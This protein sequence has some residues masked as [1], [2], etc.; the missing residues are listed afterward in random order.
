[1]KYN[2]IISKGSEI[3][4]VEISDDEILSLFPDD[5][6]SLVN[7]LLRRAQ[8]AEAEIEKLQKLVSAVRTTDHEIFCEDVNEQNWF[9]ARDVVMTNENRICHH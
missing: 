1:M 6:C 7:P 9:D 2:E 3:R 5:G 8:A 4:E